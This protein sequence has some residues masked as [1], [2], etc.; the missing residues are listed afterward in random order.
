MPASSIIA[1]DIGEKRVGVAVATHDLAVARPLITLDRQAEDFWQ[2]LTKLVSEHQTEQIVIGLPRGLEGQDTAQT[3]ATQAFG[4][5]LAKHSKLPI[6]WQDEAL[7]S[8]KA[9]ESLKMQGKLYNK[10]D[11]DALAASYIL[12]DY[13]EEQ[14]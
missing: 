4:E 1:L 5:E 10:S 12:S 6:T 11:V 7:T 3:R 9:E 2:Q 8:V 14:L 13:L